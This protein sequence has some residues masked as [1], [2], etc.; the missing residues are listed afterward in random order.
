VNG[1]FQ[2]KL[3]KYY[4]V[5]CINANHIFAERQIPSHIGLL[6]WWSKRHAFGSNKSKMADGHYFENS[7]N[8]HILATVSLTYTDCHKIARWRI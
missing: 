4:P 8:F 2:S 1:H 7:I 6:C 5:Y 3:A